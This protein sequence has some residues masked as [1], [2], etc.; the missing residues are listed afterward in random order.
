MEE[1]LKAASASPL[2]TGV[3]QEELRAMLQCLQYRVQDYPKGSYILRAGE[4]VAALGLLISGSALLIQEDYWGNRNIL[5]EVAVSQVFAEAF[6]C[7][8]GSALNMDVLAESPCRVLFLEP[9]RIISVCPASCEHHSRVIRNL[10]AD[11]ASK[12]LRLTEK[13]RHLGQRSTREKLLS[14]LSAEA[15]R[16]KSPDFEIS[17]SR[18]QLA[19]YLSVE[20]SGLSAELSR[21]QKEGILRFEK[22]HFVLRRGS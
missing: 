6:A 14:Y 11:S 1:I 5:S 13:L 9:R 16:H 22:N 15:R 4:E 18:Q 19:D 10:L 20:R 21:M 17:F 8:P 2:F 12:N 3:E 7:S